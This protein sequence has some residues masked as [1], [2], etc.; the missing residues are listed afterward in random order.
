MNSDTEN[1]E[2]N[3]EGLVSNQQKAKSAFEFKDKYTFS[4]DI[5][6]SS[7]IFI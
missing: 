4:W 2:L 3:P 6:I 1:E 5:T 7:D